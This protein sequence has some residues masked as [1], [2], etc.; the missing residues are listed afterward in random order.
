MEEHE[1]DLLEDLFEYLDLDGPDKDQMFQL[2][3]IFKQD[4]ITEP[5]FIG[6]Q[7]VG[8]DNRKSTH[9][10]FKG[11]P[12]GFEHICTRESKYSGRRN[13]DPERTNKI[14]WIK[15]VI[16][17]QADNRVKYFERLHFNGQNQRYFWLET[18][19]YVVIVREITLNLQLVTA[20]KVDKTNENSFKKWYQEYKKA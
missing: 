16:H 14:H 4:M 1:L 7:Q 12:V 6:S 15:P 3:G 9:P 2:Y 19:S 18:K 10:L 13:F 20:F 5:I 17:N 8:Y 11:K